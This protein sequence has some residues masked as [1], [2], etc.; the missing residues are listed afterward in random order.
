MRPIK[1]RKKNGRRRRCRSKVIVT[2]QGGTVKTPY[3]TV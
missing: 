2:I 1:R 3:A